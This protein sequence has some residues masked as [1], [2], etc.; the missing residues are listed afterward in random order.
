M[1]DR[2]LSTAQVV[3]W[4]MLFIKVSFPTKVNARNRPEENLVAHIYRK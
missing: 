1:G 4:E 3:F 2:I